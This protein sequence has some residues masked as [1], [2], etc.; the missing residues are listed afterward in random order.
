MGLAVSTFYH[1][2]IDW[3]SKDNNIL[4]S[5]EEYCQEMPQS[6]Y[7]PVTSYLQTK[8][9]VNKKRVQRIMQ[10]NNL[11]CKQKKRF[12]VNTTDS[13]HNL[14]KYPNLMLRRE[15]SK[16]YN[17]VIVGDITIFDIKGKN[18]YVASLLDL[19]NREP[20]G[21]SVS[22]NIDT[23]LV[24]EAFIDAKKNRKNI[25]GYMH[26]TDSD[27]RYCS[28]KYIKLLKDSGLEISMCKGNAY[29]N[30]FAESF[31]SSLKRQEINVN[32][33][34]NLQEAKESILNFRKKYIAIR[35]HSSLGGLTP[36][37]F[38][39]ENFP[40]FSTYPHNSQRKKKRSKKRKKFTTADIN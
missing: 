11:Q 39:E 28:K 26:H 10:K 37:K 34:E 29:Q 32:E 7:R 30:A 3:T 4:K 15:I 23:E 1:K 22:E 35:P 20:I 19:T 12:K 36:K 27:S 24:T 25:K 8:M 33:Y 18:H 9:N 5:I 16:D 14:R 6:G 38:A 17:K 21:I 2:K 40:E 13:K 31:N